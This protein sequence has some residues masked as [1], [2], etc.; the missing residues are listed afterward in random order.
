MIT[1]VVG[2]TWAVALKRL[3]LCPIKAHIKKD[4]WKNT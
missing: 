3:I 4:L 1:S 2:Y